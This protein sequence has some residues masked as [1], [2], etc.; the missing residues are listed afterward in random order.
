MRRGEAAALNGTWVPILWASILFY[1]VLSGTNVVYAEK[2]GCESLYLDHFLSVVRCK[3]G[4]F[5]VLG[6]LVGKY[7]AVDV[8]GVVFSLGCC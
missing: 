1:A 6:V 7:V 8:H 2:C 5:G 3:I 4:V